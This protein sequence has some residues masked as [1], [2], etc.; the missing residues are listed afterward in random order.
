MAK[1]RE[2]R[3]WLCVVAALTWALVVA[4]GSAEAEQK[5]SLPNILFILTDDMA[6]SDL[7]HMPNTQRLLADQGTTFVNHTIT[8]PTCCPSRTTFLRGQ[9]AHNHGIGMGLP[10]REKSFK[11]EGYGRSTVATWLDNE[12][13]STGLVGKYLNGFRSGSYVPPGW[14]R[15]Y[16][17]RD[18]DVWARS[19]NRDGSP[20][21]LKRG[22]IDAHLAAMGKKFVE[23]HPDTP[24]FLWQNFNAPHQYKNG[25]PPAPKPYLKKFNSAMPPKHGFNEVDVSDKPKWIRSL[26]RLTSAEVATM[27]LERQHRL[28]SLQV[29]DREVAE[30]VATLAREGELSNTYIFFT[31]DNGYHMGEHRLQ[32]GKMTPYTTDVNVPLIVRGPG[33]EEGVRRGEFVQNTDFAPTVAD[34]ADAP[35]PEFVDG[36]SMEP[37]LRGE[38]VNWRQQGFFE[39]RGG[40]AFAGITTSDGSYYIEYASGEKELYDTRKDPYQ[41]TNSYRDAN[42]SHKAHLAARVEAIK[43]CSGPSCQ[44]AEGLE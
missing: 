4:G 6:S 12:G 16:A 33:V 41:L 8:L 30:L 18:Q 14:D 35:I 7:R 24:F 19:F 22:S 13:Y 38:E 5:S 11:Q 1:R 34:L 29:V 23:Q 43:G 2:Q 10:S 36:I 31:S 28:A 25:P 27:G 17:N 42:R 40:K 9:Y 37:L 21:S 3:R 15:F 44:L 39:G 32:A 26:P 20:V